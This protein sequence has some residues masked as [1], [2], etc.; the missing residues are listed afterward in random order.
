[1]HKFNYRFP[2]S[3]L[4]LSF[5]IFHCKAIAENNL[6]HSI[7]ASEVYVKFGKELE[8]H[9]NSIKKTIKLLYAD[10]VIYLKDGYVQKI[11][12]LTSDR[13]H[14]LP[15]APVSKQLE[16]GPFSRRTA[17][18]KVEEGMFSETLTE[19]SKLPESNVDDK[20]GRSRNTRMRKRKR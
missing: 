5:F 6:N 8:R 4:L 11:R 15:D 17:D 18:Q 13:S 10:K 12:P 7:S 9:E 3:V 14:A 16:S 20:K 2:A 19:I 1:M